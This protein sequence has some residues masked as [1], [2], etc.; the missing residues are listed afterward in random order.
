MKSRVIAAAA[1]ALVAATAFTSLA[2]AQSTVN[3]AAVAAQRQQ[4]EA[5]VRAC[6]QHLQNLQQILQETGRLGL[7]TLPVEQKIRQMQ[8]A[9][10]NWAQRLAQ[11]GGNAGGRGGND[12]PDTINL[13]GIRSESP[14]PARR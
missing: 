13:L 5:Q 12:G 7:P 2:G 1:L 6:D 3:P 11:L 9:R 14:R 8:A 10:N 4:A